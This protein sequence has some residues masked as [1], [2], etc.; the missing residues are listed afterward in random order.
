MLLAE[1]ADASFQVGDDAS[2]QSCFKRERTGDLLE[3]P[4]GWEGKQAIGLK[5][6]IEGWRCF[7]PTQGSPHKLGWI[8]LKRTLPN[9]KLSC[10][11]LEKS[12]YLNWQL[13]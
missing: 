12:F 5:D 3:V 8:P 13:V 4:H 1:A 6:A 11:H 10:F 9:F 2:R 7:H